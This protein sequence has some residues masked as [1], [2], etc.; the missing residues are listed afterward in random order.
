[1][2]LQAIE[3]TCPT[4]GLTQPAEVDEMGAAIDLVPCSIDSCAKKLCP[5]C[6]FKLDCCKDLFACEEHSFD[7]DGEKVCELC[8]IRMQREQ[9]AEQLKKMWW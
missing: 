9:L 1:M 5:F 3:L 4:C 6:R 7:I 2:S 8:V